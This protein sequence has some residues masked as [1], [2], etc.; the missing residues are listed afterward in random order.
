MIKERIRNLVDD[1][2][3]IDPDDLFQ[4][5]MDRGERFRTV[6]SWASDANRIPGCMSRLWLEYHVTEQGLRFQTCS[7][8][9]MVDGTAKIV[10]DIVSDVPLAQAR[11]EAGE[12]DLLPQILNLSMQRRNGMSNLIGRVKQIIQ[13]A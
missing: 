11:S 9:L 8:S 3:I 2:S 7:D 12:L 6:P 1:V 13:Q 10:T 4:Y 5:L